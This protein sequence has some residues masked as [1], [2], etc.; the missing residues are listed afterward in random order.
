MSNIS[1]KIK[2]IIRNLESK[3]YYK[4]AYEIRLAMRREADEREIDTTAIE[5]GLGDIALDKLSDPLS[6]KIT[7]KMKPGFSANVSPASLAKGFVVGWLVDLGSNAVLDFFEK[8]G[9]PYD[10][11]VKFKGDLDKIVTI[12]DNLIDDP[13]SEELK[14]KILKLSEEGMKVLDAA[15]QEAMSSSKTKT[16]A[17]YNHRKTLAIKGDVSELPSFLR[18]IGVGAAAG[19]AGGALAGGVGAGP[20]A[21]IGGLTGLGTKAIEEVWYASISDT[22]KAFLQAKD[23][24]MKVGPMQNALNKI[25]SDIGE[26]LY[27]NVELL[28]KY[29]ESQNSDNKEKTMLEN[30]IQAAEKKLGGAA[31]KLLSEL[32]GVSSI[33]DKLPGSSYTDRL[34]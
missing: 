32:P 3:G 14:N 27:K 13:T 18:A 16:S 11:Y 7:T 10:T 34:I 6:E 5:S 15:K 8:S 22:G 31:G 4:E 23:A 30:L 1:P 29:A 17:K 28:Y 26:E 2:S 19:A 25:K 9:G 12:I 33:A 20:G 24:M 21:L